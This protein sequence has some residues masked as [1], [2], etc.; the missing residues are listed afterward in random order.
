LA[1][2]IDGPGGRKINDPGGFIN[3]FREGKLGNNPFGTDDTNDGNPNTNDGPVV[4]FDVLRYYETNEHVSDAS[5]VR[6]GNDLPI[7]A[8]LAA[9]YGYCDRYFCSHPGPTLPNRMYSLTGDVQYDRYGF[10]ILDSNDGENFVLSRAQTIYDVLTREGVGWR[11]YESEPSVTMLRMFARYAGDNVNIRPIAELEHD[12]VLGN[13]PP[14]VVIEPAMHHQPEDDDH[15]AADMYRGQVFLRRVYA[16]LT[17]NPAVWANTML[18]VT[19][20]EHGGFYDHVVPPIADV[21]EAPRPVVVDPG[22]LTTDGGATTPPSGGTHGGAGGHAGLG[23]LHVAP[24]ELSVMLGEG[25]ETVPANVAVKVPY[26]VRVPTFVVSPWVAPGKG[27]SVILDHC[28]I[29]K[30]ILARFCGEKKPFLNDRV[31]VS[32]SFEAYL[33]ENAPRPAATPP[34]LRDL[35]FTSGP[36]IAGASRIVTTPLF[37]KQMREGQVDYHEISGRL[38]RMLGR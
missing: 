10:P 28:S 5:S 8:F 35:P 38:A 29:I 13:V 14:L 7:S 1:G 9:N 36:P 12:F 31:H 11:V 26:G 16:A 18:I 27:P 24:D 25:I 30:T 15:P 6:P 23:G 22:H 19:Y 20:D 21:F 34:V 2:Q 32:H 4:P 37:R 3:N 17:A 33:T